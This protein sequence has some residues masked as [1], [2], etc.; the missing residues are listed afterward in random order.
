MIVSFHLPEQKA[1]DLSWQEVANPF[2]HSTQSGI[3]LAL[4]PQF[5]AMSAKLHSE[6]HP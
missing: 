2:S 3:D 5:I 6:G 4:A 1:S